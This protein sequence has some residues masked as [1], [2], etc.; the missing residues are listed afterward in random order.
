[1]IHRYRARAAVA[2]IVIGGWVSPAESS[3]LRMFL[4]RHCSDCHSGDAP[5]AGFDVTALRYELTDPAMLRRF[6]RIH[7]RVA[8]GEMP[9]ADAEPPPEE[10]TAAFIRALDGRLYSADA[11]RIARTGRGRLRRLTA[12]EYENSLRDLLALEHLEIH[13]LLPPDGSV[14]GYA[15]IADGLDLSPVHLAAYTAAADKAI[16][17]AIATRSGPPPVDSQRIYPA[18]AYGVFGNLIDFA[19]V[20]LRDKE[21]SPLLPLTLTKPPDDLTHDERSR[22]QTALRKLREEVLE[23]RGVNKSTETVGL[24]GHAGYGL[25]GSVPL[26]VAP[27]YPGLY[28]LRMSLWAFQWNRGAIEPAASAHAAVVWGSENTQ[29]QS[30]S[31]LLTT[32]TA[33]SF[34][35]TVQEAT[36]WLDPQEAL[37]IDPVSLDGHRLHNFRQSGGQVMEYVGPGIAVDWYEFEGP[38]LPSWPPESHRRLF[39]DLP[40]GSLPKDAGVI[41]PSRP[42]A[43]KQ[44]LYHLPKLQTEERHPPL[45]TVQSADPETD[46]RRLLEAFLPR[47]FRRPVA[48]HEVEPFVT[49]VRERLAARDCFEDAMRRAYTAALTSPGFLF[50]P[51]DT[52]GNLLTVADRLAYWLWNSPPDEALIAAALDGSLATPAVL[53]AQVDRLL[54]DSR[55]E[56]FLADF[57]DQ[58]LE[59]TRIDETSPDRLLYPEYG[60]L[61]HEA[62][63]AEPKAF[64][65]EL[66]REDMPATTLVD[67]GFA[68]LTQRLAEHYGIPGVSGVEVRR[69]AL[70]PGTHRG[71]LLGQAAIHKLTANGTTTSPVKRGVWVMDRLLDDPPLPPPPNISAIEPDTR[72]ATTVREQLARHRSNTGCMAC[73]AKIDPAGFALECFD[74][75]GGFRER[76]RSTAGGD[77]P[78]RD[79]VEQFRARYRLGPQVDPSGVL[80]DGPPFSGI[81]DLKA[82][83]AEQPRML[84]TA[85]TAH[86]IRYAT[87]ADISYADRRTIDEIVSATESGGFGIRSLI[88]G[89]AGSR[90][91]ALSPAASRS[92]VGSAAEA[93]PAPSP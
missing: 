35:P 78:P 16:S 66:I 6:V 3:D 91:I 64:L 31:R 10:E 34:E 11:A 83:L 32:L 12:E 43:N 7:D 5:E 20:L 39:G 9:P 85:F 67:S 28:K 4:E 24:L 18:Q 30:G 2:L 17:E 21:R 82:L 71:G 38:L 73:H 54:A 33:P 22:W 81:D 88:H 52:P 62:A 49:V 72:G 25:S 63:I 48:A 93:L 23:D 57:C 61:L 59:L 65:R 68:M 19:A 86:M 46:A 55:S 8:R 87:G 51:A 90:L 80:P 53:H 27:I 45:E 42:Q 69:I 60:L 15:K 74:P 37:V 36:F 75:I 29:L 13:D 40:I 89:I 79:A 50:H 84:A 70:P 44:L 58:W 47:A 77:P 14:A 76:Y 56:R 1:M 41:P 26:C 92:S